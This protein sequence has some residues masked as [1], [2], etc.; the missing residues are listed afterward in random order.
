MVE[1]IASMIMD[2]AVSNESVIGEIVRQY[3]DPEERKLVINSSRPR[4]DGLNLL[5]CALSN[6]GRHDLVKFLMQSGADPNWKTWNGTHVL[7]FRS[8]HVQTDIDNLMTLLACGADSGALSQGYSIIYDDLIY[9]RSKYQP[10][11]QVLLTHGASITEEE[12]EIIRK[13]RRNNLAAL[14]DFHKHVSLR[15]IALHHV[16]LGTI[17]TLENL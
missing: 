10:I 14:I 6:R 16:R 11:C 8:L 17:R 13:R 3:P 9:H 12:Y 7:V 15:R 1:F 5:T 2:G 4:T